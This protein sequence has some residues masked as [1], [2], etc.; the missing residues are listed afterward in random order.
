MSEPAAAADDARSDF[1]VVPVGSKLLLSAAR[2]LAQASGY[3]GEDGGSVFLA[4][5]RSQS[6]DLRL[7]WASVAPNRG[8]EARQVVLAVPGAGRTAVCFTTKPEGAGSE[9]ELSRVVEFGCRSMASSRRTD[10]RLAQAILQ[11]RETAAA[12]A[13]DAAGFRTVGRLEYLRRPRP[14]A[15]AFAPVDAWPEGVEVRTYR[16]G[17]DDELARALE[18][19]YADTLD[20]PELCG[21]RATSDVI[22]SHRS[23]GSWDPDFWRLVRLGGEPVGASLFNPCP[24][25]DTVE[26][27][28]IGL[29]P[30]ARGLGLGRLLMR[31]GLAQASGR[32]ERFVTCAGDARNRPAKGLYDKLGFKRFDERI[33]KVL[34]LGGRST[35]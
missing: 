21:L 20:C 31:E 12:A 19:S 29:A 6:V 5:A 15:G 28:Y 14:A 16:S 11:P 4:G 13:F 1:E 23:V 8:G 34:P 27:V 33:A 24:A 17:D 32:P 26:L 3:M 22:E 18:A 9:A 2:R 35:G 30:R 25:G 7:M 10:I